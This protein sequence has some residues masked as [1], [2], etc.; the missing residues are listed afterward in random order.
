V[1]ASKT[2]ETLSPCFDLLCSNSPQFVPKSSAGSDNGYWGRSND[3]DP[4]RDSD[5]RSAAPEMV[6][7]REGAHRCSGDGAWCS[8]VDGRSRGRN[9]SEPA[10]SL[11]P[12]IAWCSA[13][14]IVNIR[15]PNRCCPNRCC[16]DNRG[17][18]GAGSDRS[19]VYDW[20]AVTDLRSCGCLDCGGGHAGSDRLWEAVTIP[21]LRGFK[22]ADCND[23]SWLC[24][25]CFRRLHRRFWS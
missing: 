9:T 4:G 6:E 12:A 20:S 3:G 11:A 15:G 18:D 16:P 13:V 22:H 7:S 14:C 23:W 25:S 8:C 21:E 10:V 17:A 24:R 19:G 5:F 2:I 1:R